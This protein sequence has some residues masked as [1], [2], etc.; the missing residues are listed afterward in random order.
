MD[1]GSQQRMNQ[2][3][4]PDR[5]YFYLA[6]SGMTTPLGISTAMTATAVKASICAYSL[7]DYYN[8]DFQPVKVAAIPSALFDGQDFDATDWTGSHSRRLA[9][10]TTLAVEQ[11]FANASPTVPIPFILAMPEPGQQQESGLGNHLAQHFPDWINPA[12]GR[13]IYSGRAAGIEALAFAFDYLYDQPCEFIL[14]GGSDSYLDDLRLTALD[15]ADRLATPESSN[16]FVPAEASA[17]LLLTR[18]PE[19]ALVVNGHRIAL[20]PPGIAE[21]PG[22]LS[23]DEPYRGDGLDQAFKKALAYAPA[24]PIPR[25]YSSMNGEHYWAKEYG[26][27]YLRNR[28]HFSESVDIKHPADAYG[29]IGSATAPVLIALAAQQLLAAAKD[30]AYLVYSSSDGPK[31]GAIILEKIAAE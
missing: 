23:S 3:S 30:H 22:H 6:A 31:R 16:G 4:A 1:Q 20:H 28:Q 5:K 25:I 14:I 18:N 11:V 17:F 26:V 27:A 29:D 13:S 8:R 2:Y 21:E 9:F 10:I 7:S 12:L 24:Q 19:H 15:Q